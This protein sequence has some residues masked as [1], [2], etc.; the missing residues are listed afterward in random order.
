MQRIEKLSESD[1]V[2]LGALMCILA[3]SV[4]GVVIFADSHGALKALRQSRMP[5]GQVYLAG[6]LNLTRRF[7]E[8]GIRIEL[9]WIPAH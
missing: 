9:G 2:H 4:V 5:S 3:Q 7:A 1:E 6:C 8:R